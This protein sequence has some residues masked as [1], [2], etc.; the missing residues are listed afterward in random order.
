MTTVSCKACRANE[1]FEAILSVLCSKMAGRKTPSFGEIQ[2]GFTN[3]VLSYFRYLVKGAV[4]VGSH[5]SYLPVHTL[6]KFKGKDCYDVVN[7][8]K[9]AKQIGCNNKNNHNHVGWR[10]GLVEWISRLPRAMP[11]TTDDLLHL[12]SKQSLYPVIQ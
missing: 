7:S 1:A 4:Y 10:R 6:P 5:G 9:P 2:G 8:I 12:R 3:C 11:V